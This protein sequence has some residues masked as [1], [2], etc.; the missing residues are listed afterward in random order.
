MTAPTIGLADLLRDATRTLH[1]RAERSG[2]VAALIRGRARREEYA[3]LLR[4]LLPPYRSLEEA[5]GRRR[6]SVGIGPLA[7]P[8]VFRSAALEADLRSL[9][10]PD[11][12]RALPVLPAGRDYAQRIAASAGSDARLLAHAYVRYLGDLNGG[13]IVAR[14][15]G[16]ALGLPPRA[17]HFYAYPEVSDLA[18]LRD[19]YRRAVDRAAPH[20]DPEA[21]LDEARLAFELNI[22]LSEAVQRRADAGTLLRPAG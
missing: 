12:A 5:L 10:G 15:L 6:G 21:A 20:V 11:W 18:P 4:N 19:A 13:R 7:D 22:A 3:L 2:V 9:A 17:L 14:R 16:Q 8:V 1:D